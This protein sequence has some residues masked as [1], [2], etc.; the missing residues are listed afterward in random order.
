MPDALTNATQAATR[1]Q[2]AILALN[3]KITKSVGFQIIV[4]FDFHKYYLCIQ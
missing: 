1:L 2:R 3:R 4:N